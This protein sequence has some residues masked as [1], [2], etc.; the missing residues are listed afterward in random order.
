MAGKASGGSDGGIE[1]CTVDLA[2]PFDWELEHLLYSNGN[3]LVDFYPNNAY[4]R[5]SLTV[6]KNTMLFINLVG[7]L[8]DDPIIVGDAEMIYGGNFYSV[9]LFS[10][11]GDCSINP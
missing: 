7:E 2:S 6:A 11:N 4:D 3:E 8:T 5:I 9:C 10:I 1:T